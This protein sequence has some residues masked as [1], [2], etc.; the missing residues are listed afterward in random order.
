MAKLTIY[1]PDD[2]AAA[3]REAG[4]STSPVCQRALAQEVRNVKARTPSEDQLQAAIAR[5]NGEADDAH[6]M[7]FD[8]GLKDGAEWALGYASADELDSISRL[9]PDFKFHQEYTPPS[10]NGIGPFQLGTDTFSVA[11]MEG[12]IGVWK[13]I[14]DKVESTP[15]DPPATPSTPSTPSTEEPA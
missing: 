9:G 5:L 2:L 7:W 1:L 12:A 10:W 14:R 8:A 13:K 11:F 15:S 6:L 4:I 3:V